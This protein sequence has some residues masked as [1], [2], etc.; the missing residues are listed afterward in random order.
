[1]FNFEVFQ[2]M[3]ESAVFINIGRGPTVVEN[4]LIRALKEKTIAGAVLD[5]FQEEPLD[6]DSELWKLPNIFMT[7]HCA[8]QAIDYYPRSMRIFVDNLERYANGSELRN[9][10]DK[11]KGY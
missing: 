5:V 11:S 7:P 1:M 9:I 10:V 6:K 3:K 4:D 2:K 8:D